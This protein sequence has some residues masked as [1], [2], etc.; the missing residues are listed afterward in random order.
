M[1]TSFAFH[2]T[3]H[4]DACG[5]FTLDNITRVEY[6][7]PFSIFL[8][9][10]AVATAAVDMTNNTIECVLVVIIIALVST[11][12]YYEYYEEKQFGS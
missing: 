5:P 9:S 8:H 12:T 10:T 2:G 1:Y 3:G 6:T 11:Y 4:V 7:Q